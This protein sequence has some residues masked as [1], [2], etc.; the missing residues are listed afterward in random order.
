MATGMCKERQ[1][2]LVDRLYMEAVKRGDREAAEFAL[3]NIKVF[4]KDCVD[5]NGDSAI[6][7]AIDTR[8]TEMLK[9][10]LDYK[11][12][13]R[14]SLLKAV[15]AEYIEAVELICE[16]AEV[17]SNK[18]ILEVTS[19]N[20]DFNPII[21]PIIHAAHLNNYHII[22]I[23]LK[24]GS[25]ICS[26]SKWE[27]E[28]DYTLE[29]CIST[30][31]IYRALSS[32]A[33]IS[34]TALDPINEA[35]RLSKRLQ[36]LK[37]WRVEFGDE[38]HALAEQCASYAADL[39]DHIRSSQEQ[40][41]LFNY[42]KDR[43]DETEI[44]T[45]APKRVKLAIDC[46]QKKFVAHRFCQQYLTETWYRDLSIHRSQS[47]I[48]TIIFTLSA[49]L[50]FPVLAVANIL[51][52]NWKPGRWIEIPYIKFICHSASQFTFFLLIIVNNYVSTHDPNSAANETDTLTLLKY[53]SI[54][55]ISIYVLSLTWYLICEINRQAVQ[56][57]TLYDAL[58]LSLFWVYFF[59]SITTWIQ[60]RDTDLTS[61]SPSATALPN[62][63]IPV[64]YTWLKDELDGIKK[65][66]AEKS[67][68]KTATTTAS[69]RKLYKPR[70]YN[71][72][73]SSPDNLDILILYADVALAFAKVL[74]VL[75]MMTLLVWSRHVG[76]MH[77]SL[78][79][80][81]VDIAKFMLIFVFVWFA[82]SLGMNQIYW[83]YEQD[84]FGVIGFKTLTNSL[85]SLFW[86]LFG[87]SETTVF[88]GHDKYHD[89]TEVAGMGMY[90]LYHVFAIVVLLNLLIAMMS[91][92]Y[93]KIEEDADIEWKYAR[94]RL[95]LE[96]FDD[97]ITIPPPFNLLPRPGPCFRRLKCIL[98]FPCSESLK[99][100]RAGYSRAKSQF[101]IHYKK[102]LSKIGRR[103][104]FDSKEEFDETGK[105]M[106]QTVANL[107]TDMVG[108]LR[109]INNNILDVQSILGAPEKG[110]DEMG[111]NLM[112]ALRLSTSDS[113]DSVRS[114]CE[115]STNSKL[116]SSY[117][118]PFHDEDEHIFAERSKKKDSDTTTITDTDENHVGN[119]SVSF[120]VDFIDDME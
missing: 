8:N 61:T 20:G 48:K 83:Y 54:I 38:F 16:Y 45:L 11:V 110:V 42:A 63:T 40:M 117:S 53:A 30:Y 81:L 77:I 25:E 91:N 46:G 120:G 114:G 106:V 76:P 118:I 69:K 43:K 64:E 9:L 68:S 98:G 92:T 23:L 111:S 100:N 70:P 35:F 115:E 57:K 84:I 13:V 58:Y 4:D 51:S 32:P 86:S 3:E 41:I 18:A 109:K 36:E 2:R 105:V 73:S 28:E 90:S 15:D 112:H 78:L 71:G 52:R 33:Y 94:S 108:A 10:L 1:N 87:V 85:L 31:D 72:D 27:D 39:L 103:Y 21:T 12:E 56:W 6:D 99:Q 93:T 65:V 26:P 7:L 88:T 59:I 116:P 79:R 50:L 29:S 113:I 96:Y 37:Y 119:N 14:D 101:W 49:A 74:A 80:T 24:N 97:N 89:I 82:F 22:K 102:L 5:R 60:M 17:T 55:L 107:Q 19:R 47:S 95:W 44:K 67:T 34:L 66:C 104:H 75:R 62:S